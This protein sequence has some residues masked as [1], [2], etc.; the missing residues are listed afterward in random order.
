M[1]KRKHKDYNYQLDLTPF[2]SLLSV[3]IC[4]LLLTVAW[5]Q[6]G[7]LNLRQVIGGE[8]Q[9]IK[10][11]ESPSLWIHL[12]PGGIQVKLKKSSLKQSYMEKKVFRSLAEAKYD[13]E[14]FTSYLK[15]LKKKVPDLNQAFLI[16]KENTTY[17]D[18]IKT[19]DRVRSVGIFSLGISPI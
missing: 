9:G 12:E 19:M 8:S 3:C 7:S 14:K 6:V 18:I 4:F 15:K 5:F 13:F 16:P 1:R 17:E 2:I 10:K 11:K